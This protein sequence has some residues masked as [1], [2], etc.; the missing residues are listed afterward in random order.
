M[1]ASIAVLSAD[2]DVKVILPEDEVEL[3]STTSGAKMIPYHPAG[4]NTL[5]NPL[6]MLKEPLRSV[7]NALNSSHA[8]VGL[9]LDNGVQPS[10]YAVSYQF[11][12]SLLGLLQEL[13]PQSNFAACD[14]LVE[15]MKAVKTP[16]ELDHIQ[17]SCDFAAAG[18]DMAQSAIH[19]G[20]RETEIAA[21][22]QGAFEAATQAEGLERS[23][24]YFFCMSGP[25]SA[26]AA[27]AYA[28]TR[29]R[30]VEEGDLVMIHANT[31]ADGY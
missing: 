9:Q 13:Q 19:S 3:A 24:G 7:M 20:M 4:L 22:I 23:Y 16:R 18:F 11:R 12:S 25:N 29:Q 21:A 8:K 2:G 1:G 28:R 26:K 31:C 30:V 27:A 17:K 14:E 15:Q 6:Q 5:K 10:S